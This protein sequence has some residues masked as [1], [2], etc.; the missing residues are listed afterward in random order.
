[1]CECDRSEVN[2]HNLCDQIPH[3]SVKS[4]RSNGCC[5]P[6][7]TSER[8]PSAQ[9]LALISR[10]GPRRGPLAQQRHAG[11]VAGSERGGSVMKKRFLSGIA[12]ASA[13]ALVL[14]GCASEGDG[15][16]PADP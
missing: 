7:V 2:P 13:S 12:V 10:R 1:M 11:T 9:M 3:F 8:L 4:A 6:I 14:V 5:Y 15:D 16:A